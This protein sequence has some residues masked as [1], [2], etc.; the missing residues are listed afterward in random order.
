[1]IARYSITQQMCPIRTALPP[2]SGRMPHF[3]VLLQP[4]SS[5]PGASRFREGDALIARF[6][7]ILKEEG[8]R[9]SDL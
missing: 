2:L 3:F 1:M 6:W 8:E 9:K 7:E 5:T 4:P